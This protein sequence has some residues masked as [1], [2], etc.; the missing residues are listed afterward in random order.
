MSLAL[1]TLTT[2]SLAAAT[3]AGTL[4]MV[5]LLVR[6]LNAIDLAFDDGRDKPWHRGGGGH[7]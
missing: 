5:A 3:L 7:P 2:A 1:A 6:V 4:S